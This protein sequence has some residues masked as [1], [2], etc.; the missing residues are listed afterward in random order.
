MNPDDRLL[1][2]TIDEWKGKQVLLSCYG[3]PC[4]DYQHSLEVVHHID[5]DGRHL[6]PTGFIMCSVCG[7]L[8]D[9]PEP[10][11]CDRNDGEESAE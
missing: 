8:T 9:E 10:Y 11:E 1:Y 4:L 7:A 5:N 6:C 2:A 3:K